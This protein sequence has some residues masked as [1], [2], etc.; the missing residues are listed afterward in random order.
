MALQTSIVISGDSASATA[1]LAQVEQALDKATAAAG[2]NAAANDDAGDKTTRS[3]GQVRQAYNSLG[4]QAQDVAVQLQGG[5]SLG[6]I[7]SQQGGQVADALEGM[8]GKF[9]GLGAFLSGPWGAAVLFGASVLIDKLAPA[10]FGVSDAT[11][12][13][14]SGT[15]TFTEVLGDS[16]A[17]WEEVTAAAREYADQ[18]AKTNQT[19][20]AA[21]QLEAQL[22]AANLQQAVATRKKIAANIE[23]QA[24]LA[25]S[26]ASGPNGG[27]TMG[28]TAASVSADKLKAANDTEITQ[29]IRA[30]DA[31]K[32]KVATA[33]AKINADP[34][35]KIKAG[36][37]EL[38][39]QAMASGASVDDLTKRL[40]A[41]NIAEQRA[42][43]ARQ[44]SQRKGPD[45]AKAAA[46]EA[47]E[48]E[49][50]LNFGNDAARQIAAIKD[51]F[52][53][54]PAVVGRSNS[55]LR[56]LDKI[57]GAITQKNPPNLKV[58]LA[59]IANARD[60]INDSLNRPFA[61]YLEQAAEAAQIDKLLIAG[62]VDQAQALRD[63]L[64]IERN[65]NALN[66]DEL[67]TVLKTV[68]AERERSLVL[69]DRS[70]II[71]AQIGAVRDL[72][73][74]LV[75]T[76]A[77][78][79]KGRFTIDK[80]LSSIGNSYINITAQKIVEATF[81]QTL[82]ELEQQASALDPV[83]KAGVEL[84][85]Q[86]RAG[87]DA[88]KSFADVLNQARVRMASG[89][90]SVGPRSSALPSGSST[91]DA[92]TNE[93]RVEGNRTQQISLSP[94]QYFSKLGDSLGGALTGALNKAFNTRFFSSM[95]DAFSGALAG[96]AFGRTF[97][98]GGAAIGGGI[99]ALS[100]ILGGSGGRDTFD[101]VLE[102]L[103]SASPEIAAAIAANQGLNTLLGNDDRVGGK[104]LHT[105]LGP[106]I[107]MLFA[108][109]RG[110]GSI[111]DG[112]VSASGNDGQIVS[113]LNTFGGSV[114]STIS[115][116]ADQFGAN[117]GS[118]DVGIGRYKDYFQVS[119]SGSD[120]YLGGSYFQ[121]KS[122]NALYDGKD[123]AAATAAAISDA[124]T[125]GA[126]QGISSK[127]AA[128]LKSSSDID[129]AVREAL[130]VQDL[131]LALGGIGEELR[132]QFAQF[133]QQAQERLRI[134]GKY[135]FDVVA[136]EKRNAE[137]RVK[138][139]EKLAKQQ[140]GSLQQLIDDLTA[141]SLFEGSAVDQRTAI[142]GKIDKAR[143]DANAGVEGAA[144]TLSQ[145]LQQLNTVSKDAYGTTG[146]F[147]QDRQTILDVARDTI[148]QANKRVTDAQT[149]ASDPALSETNA[150]LNESNDQLARI[151]S[152][153]DTNA[154]LLRQ[155]IGGGANY[156][157]LAAAAR[158]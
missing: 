12:E 80:V 154:G 74:A 59:D 13:A 151:A 36:F 78:T 87:G 61:D 44:K 156:A 2:R 95:T 111:S 113:S 60:A 56:E 51:Q 50:R 157:S 52:S 130:K 118:Y 115:K 127:V 76:V 126:I 125:D 10:L 69:R 136:V 117:V 18:L 30:A 25:R 62:K 149:K 158:I 96:A 120:S 141:G 14:A 37:D 15:R 122:S 84:A 137:D 53:D 144:E 8:G 134:A 26:V 41:L 21:I 88:V 132:R 3:A 101:G 27:V 48:A 139:Q 85:G 73:G 94:V 124:I 102:S 28:P 153:M 45:P 70:E 46:R 54:L 16:K 1:A 58:L 71:Q 64:A 39:R 97:G 11:D 145:L 68:Q 7:L 152:G 90:A 106:I 20:L 5:T 81:G 67:A 108:A 75:E 123:A 42:L 65:Q 143:A 35:E 92:N 6:T 99:G 107:S 138:L 89:D 47:R 128:A 63:M 147:A 114:Q 57:A 91:Y 103:S 119:R 146:G 17:S 133:E 121:S 22:I 98:P 29:L 82:R 150:Q 155:L 55:A 112:N 105:L 110:S 38:R 32:I 43:D 142:K 66:D 33:V 140:V 49:Q 77:D 109:K 4:Q 104:F 9:A 93:I 34:T 100:S 135:G 31:V 72:R 131:E 116:I 79:F 24:S 23:L 129:K 19:T 40:T 83:K 148:A 86:F